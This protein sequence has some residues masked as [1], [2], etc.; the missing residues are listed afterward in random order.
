MRHYC[1]NLEPRPTRRHSKLGTAK[2]KNVV[3][4]VLIHRL[5]FDA[6]SFESQRGLHAAY[7]RVLSRAVYISSV[8]Y[9][10]RKV[11]SFQ[12]VRGYISEF[13]G[14]QKSEVP[15]E[16]ASEHEK[17][18][19]GEALQKIYSQNTPILSCEKDWTKDEK[20]YLF[21]PDQNRGLQ[22]MRYVRGV[23]PHYPHI[24][25]QQEPHKKAGR[26]CLRRWS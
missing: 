24:A 2:R 17:Q 7:D 15:P 5:V 11:S 13:L 26:G 12:L 14:L 3:I 1:I 22:G 18:V 4:R 8:M 9:E 16:L 6:K 20:V 23:E 10:S 21:R 25:T 19:A